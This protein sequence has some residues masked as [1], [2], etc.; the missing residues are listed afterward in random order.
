MI[1]ALRGFTR[2]ISSLIASLRSSTKIY[3]ED[4]SLVQRLQQ[5][6][7]T[8]STSLRPQLVA[9]G[10]PPEVL[11]PPERS[12]NKLL[13][14]S[15]KQ[16]HRALFVKLLIALRTSVVNQVLLEVASVQPWRTTAPATASENLL[17]EVSDVPNELIP[18]A[19]LGSV[20]QMRSFMKRHAFE[21]N[22]FI[23]IR[24]RSHLRN[25]VVRIKGALDELGFDGILAREHDL[26]DDLYNPIACLLCCNY[27]IAI[28]DRSEAGQVHNPNIVYELAVMQ[29]LK[30]RCL[31][32]KHQSL[33][34]MPTDF[35]HK[36]YENYDR[37]LDA[38]G[39][40]RAWLRRIKSI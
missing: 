20:K 12:L 35:L 27:G 3:V 37:G 39:R 8:W 17:P 19:L 25:L 5:L 32:L 26:T 33:T 28:F 29:L 6:F 23:M 9:I 36:L 18:N 10:V 1:E 40:V 4:E 30:R 14:L 22:V 31:I 16:S 2:E 38:A 7:L 24:Y 11:R 34:S 15:R 13:R 21:R